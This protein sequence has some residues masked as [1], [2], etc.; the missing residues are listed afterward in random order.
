MSFAPVQ[1][2][3]PV[4]SLII[5]L[6]AVFAQF[7]CGGSGGSPPPP[8]SDFAVSNVFVLVLENHSFSGVIGNPAMPYLNSL[9]SSNAVGANYF[10]NTHPSIGNYFMMTTGTIPTNDDN[11]SG[12]VTD[13]NIVRELTAANKS[14]KGYFD[15]LPS[16]GYTGGDVLPYVKH[17]NP[18]AYF[19]DVLNSQAQQANIVP[20]TQL[21]TD[22][23]SG[24]LPQFG[25]IA[26]NDYENGHQC[27]PGI[28][29][30]DAA[31]LGAADNWLRANIDP[32]IKSAAFQ[33]GGLLFIVFDESVTTDTTNG[34]GQVPL[35]AVSPGVRA[36]FQSST[37]Y[38]HQ[39]L[40]KT[41]LQE[42]GV[43]VAP[44]AA[45]TASPM[46]DFFSTH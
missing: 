35:I 43:N 29:C 13:D 9:A 16:V 37:F 36:G 17:H 33:K 46:S 42:L 44:G 7:G 5:L 41:V 26:P 15:S 32:L 11:F 10:A 27:S 28:T 8:P 22:V 45:A 2:Q 20:A 39:N 31:A 4:I 19:T 18:F 38:Q 21:A 30:T 25:F 1:K 34:G 23:A 14:W 3:A 6:V 40:L 24:Q 12:T